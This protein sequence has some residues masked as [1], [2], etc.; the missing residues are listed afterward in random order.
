MNFKAD[1]HNRKEKV[2]YG[3]SVIGHPL[4]TIS[5]FILVY[6]YLFYD[7]KTTLSA[8]ALIFLIVIIPVSVNNYWQAKKGFITNF[9]VSDRKQRASLFPYLLVLVAIM[10]FVMYMYNFPY[11]ITHGVLFFFLMLLVITVINLKLKASLHAASSMFI[12]MMIVNI[13]PF[14]GFAMLFFSLVVAW[15]RLVLKRHT[16]PEIIAGLA[17]GI[18]FGWLG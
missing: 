5:V 13:N 9:D 2:A 3:I 7:V 14:V 18:L 8:F 15:S 1:L 6:G 10:W 11:A 12:C 17:A 16:L 4:I